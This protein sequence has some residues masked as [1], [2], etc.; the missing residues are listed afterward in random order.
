MAIACTQKLST[1]KPRVTGACECCMS[2]PPQAVGGLIGGFREQQFAGPGESC[3]PDHLLNL[4]RRIAPW[5][6]K[7]VAHSNGETECQA[8]SNLAPSQFRHSSGAKWWPDGCMPKS[9]AS[10]R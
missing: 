4:T 8:R 3:A 2:W 7:I 10:Q 1:D 5:R 9:R 6:G